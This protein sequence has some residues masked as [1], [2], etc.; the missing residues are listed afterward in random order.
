MLLIVGVDIHSLFLIE[1]SLLLTYNTFNNPSSTFIAAYGLWSVI[2]ALISTF[3]FSMITLK[4]A[5]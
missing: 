2:S 4:I 5:S 3:T 1:L